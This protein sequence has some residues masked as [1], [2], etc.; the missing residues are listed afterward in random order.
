MKR[1][2]LLALLGAFTAV[3]VLSGCGK[4]EVVEEPKAEI[5]TSKDVAETTEEPTPEP[6]PE[7]EQ[8]PEGM[9]K[10]YLTGEHVPEAIG[11]RRPVAIMLNNIVDAVPQY[12]IS[13]AGVVYEAPVEGDIT[14]LMGIFENY[15]DLEKIGSV[16]SSRE[17][18]IFF[19]HEF[20]AL[21][22]HFGQ[23]AYAVPFLEQD[24][25]HNLS[26]LSDYGDDIYYRTS[27]RKAPHNVYTSF[28]GIQKG[29]ADYGYTQTY[30]SEYD[31]HYQFAKVGESVD[32]QESDGAT[33]ANLIKLDCFDFNKPWFEYDP[34]T[35][36]Y[37]RF[38]YGDIQIDEMTGEQ[39]AFDNIL[40]QYTSYVPHDSNGYLNLDVISG[41]QGKYIT[42]GK[43]IDVEWAKDEPWGVTHYI[44]MQ[45]QEITMNTGTTFVAI[46]LNDT[47]DKLSIQ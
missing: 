14:R 11:N 41:G 43:A 40:I 37:K 35:Q 7:G 24:F 22:A 15:D 31:G 44:N 19:A 47:L 38:Q 33:A 9:V 12:G 25:I 2:H 26:G 5:I 28:A 23:A 39:L 4:K 36:K 21:Y 27:D 20:D 30:D 42:H 3:T 16:R 17:Y 18:Y 32:L 8:I 6:T 29:I 1:L 45:N 13:R 10:S 34:E 46:V